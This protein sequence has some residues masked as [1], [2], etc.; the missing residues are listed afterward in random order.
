MINVRFNIRNPWSKR[1]ENVKCWAWKVSKHKAIELEILKST[2]VVEFNIVITHRQSHAGLD[3]EIGL[4]GYNVHFMFYDG[5][6]WD[7][8]LDRW[9]IYEDTNS[10]TNN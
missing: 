4:L 5:R 9:E 8:T 1:F 2:D 10:K 6:H 3:I 7:H